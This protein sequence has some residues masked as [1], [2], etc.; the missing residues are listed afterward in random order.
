MANTTNN[1]SDQATLWSFDLVQDTSGNPAPGGLIL[2]NVRHDSHNYAQDVRV[3]GIWLKLELFDPS[4]ATAKALPSRFVTLSPKWFDTDTVRQIGANPS[5][6]PV[7]DV[8]MLNYF[9]G[10]FALKAIYSS[11]KDVFDGL[12]NCQHGLL[13][14]TQLW[15]FSPY[16]NSPPHEPS[17]GLSAARFHPT[18]KYK[19][20]DSTHWD[21]T[22]PYTRVSSIRF[23]YRLHLHVDRSESSPDAASST[24]SNHAGLFRDRD[25]PPLSTKASASGAGFTYVAFEAAEKP[26]A[27]EVVGPALYQGLAQKD[28]GAASG[29]PRQIFEKCWD[30]IHWWGHRQQGHISAPGAFHAV[31]MHWRWGAPIALAG[32]LFTTL[33]QAPDAVPNPGNFLPP[34]PTVLRQGDIQNGTIF[35]PLVDSN[36]WTQTIYVAVTKYDKTMD[37]DQVDPSKCSTETF[38]DLFTSRGKP[39]DIYSGANCV[40]WYSTEIP[41][42]VDM[43]ISYALSDPRGS[44]QSGPTNVSVIAGNS[45][46]VLLHGTFFAHDP[47]RTGK[48]IGDTAELYLQRDL[49]TIQKQQQWYRP[50][51]T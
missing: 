48:F 13:L 35:G 40:M 4:S 47:E 49:A 41:R 30:N 2:Q 38:Q 18:L 10:G 29:N 6:K 51:Q 21:S 15:M 26:L 1:I 42:E 22:K 32:G 46:Y 16:G 12:T 3:I 17:G 11:T 39:Q 28:L 20:E 19:L 31:H 43:Q 36:I 24:P 9:T 23:D 5:V 8:M 33:G 34:L 14:I 25:V 44:G 27:L 45:G 7:D 37:P 50:P